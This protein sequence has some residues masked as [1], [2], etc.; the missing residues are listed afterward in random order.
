[1]YCQIEIILL[2]LLFLFLTLTATR[3]LIKV[4]KCH[5]V[6]GANFSA[7]KTMLDEHWALNSGSDVSKNASNSLVIVNTLCELIKAMLNSNARLLIDTSGS[8]C[9]TKIFVV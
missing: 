9:K 1:M 3:T 2:V 8:C 6:L 7:A 4:S 5:R